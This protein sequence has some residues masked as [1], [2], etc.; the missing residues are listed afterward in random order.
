MNRFLILTALSFLT[1]AGCSDDNESTPAINAP[2]SYSFERD[3]QST[4]SFS[5]Q[6]TRIMMADELNDNMKGLTATSD[7]L[8]EMFRNSTAEGGDA[9]PYSSADL[10]T[11]TKSIKEKVAASVDYF[12]ANTVES[13][14]IKAQFEDWITSQ[15]N[16]VFANQNQLAEPGVPG[17][18]ADGSSTRYVNA[19]G[20]ELNQMVAKGL[21]GALMTDQ[22]LNNYLSP[23]VLDANND[24]ENNNAK[25]VEDGSNYTSMEHHWDEAYG[26]IYGMSVDYAN[27]NNTI[28]EDDDFLNEYVG[29]VNSNENFAG[30]AD[31]IFDAFKLGRTAIVEGDYDLRDAQAVIIK[32]AISKVIAVRAVHYLQGGKGEL[33]EDRT[34]TSLYGPA[35]HELSEALGFIYSLRFTQNPITGAS[36]FTAEEVDTMI[37]KI[38]GSTNG[39]WD[40]EGSVLDEISTEIATKFGFTVD[41]AS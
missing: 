3:G 9:N 22:I 5:G 10:N 25:L 35:L 17:Q 32:E 1:L 41:Q 33:P 6:K 8:L 16:D 14:A 24:R 19:K 38:Y 39:L 40:V 26:Y 37:D 36:Y 29:V 2:I 27:P 18:L 11:A 21:L 20:L 15:A 7:Q 12:S 31:V 30:I 4:V 34:A 28:G 13:S 23:S